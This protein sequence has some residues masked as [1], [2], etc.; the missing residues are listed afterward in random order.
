V[1]NIGT[2][3][4]ISL[5]EVIEQMGRAL[6]VPVKPTFGPARAGDVRDSV[7]DITRARELLGYEPIVDFGEGIA[8]T[9]KTE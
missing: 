8:R 6:N 4:R 1:F 5:L 7:A 9:L 2:G 3:R